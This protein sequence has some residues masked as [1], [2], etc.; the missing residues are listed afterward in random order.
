VQR[1]ADALICADRWQVG[2]YIGWPSNG[3]SAVESALPFRITICGIAELP[4]HTEV[5][6]SHVLSILDPGWPVPD[7]F[8]GF[9]EHAR[10]ELRFHDIIDEQPGMM[11]PRPEHVAEIL[12]FGRDLLAEP[13]GTANLLVHCHAGVSRST[14]SMILLTAQALPQAPGPALVDTILRI[15]PQAWPNLRIVEMGDAE[16]R[17]GG[18]LVAAVAGL[19]R[20]Q[21]LRRPDYADEMTAGG[22]GREVALA[23]QP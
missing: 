18:T 15:R 5:G 19:Y 14:A 22:R 3:V 16:L 1:L 6:V 17:R 12:A 13:A 9:G 7:A 10:L 23:Q 8:G 2:R 21:L 20:S 11:L 4:D